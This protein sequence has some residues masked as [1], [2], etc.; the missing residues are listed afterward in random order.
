MRIMMLKDNDDGNNSHD[1]ND[2]N[3]S[4]KA[5]NIYVVTLTSLSRTCLAFLCEKK[6]NTNI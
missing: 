3:K 1:N 4:K 5:R 2:N 6:K